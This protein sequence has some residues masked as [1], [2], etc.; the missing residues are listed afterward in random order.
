MRRWRSTC[1]RDGILVWPR[2]HCCLITH[3]CPKLD[4]EFHGMAQDEINIVLLSLSSSL[5]QDLLKLLL[6]EQFSVLSPFISPSILFL[7]LS[8]SPSSPQ[9]SHTHI[10]IIFSLLLMLIKYIFSDSHSKISME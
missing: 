10:H 7:F 9:P 6:T 4:S 5:Y 1:Q 2:K 8:F 3:S